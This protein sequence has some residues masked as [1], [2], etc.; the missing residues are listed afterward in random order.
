MN[1][2]CHSAVTKQE[3]AVSDPLLNTKAAPRC[4]TPEVVQHDCVVLIVA[5]KLQEHQQQQ[6]GCRCN[7][8]A[9]SKA[10]LDLC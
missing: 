2:L 4:G 9:G 6:C 1:L 10:Q 7:V 8:S 3:A 5:I